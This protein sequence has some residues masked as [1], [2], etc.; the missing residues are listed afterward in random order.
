MPTEQIEWTDRAGTTH[1]LRLA[2]DL[3]TNK[4]GRA[5][6]HTNAM[7]CPADPFHA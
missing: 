4:A 3:S 5:P 7:P 2:H 1:S 6:R